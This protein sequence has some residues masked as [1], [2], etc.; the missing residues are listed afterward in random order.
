MMYQLFDFPPIIN[1]K[2]RKIKVSGHVDITLNQDS[3]F[4]V[5]IGNCYLKQDRYRTQIIPN[6]V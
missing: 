1:N 6:K 5:S 2:I 3:L 4:Y